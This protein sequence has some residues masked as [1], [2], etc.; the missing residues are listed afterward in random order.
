MDEFRLNWKMFFGRHRPA[1]DGVEKQFLAKL[2]DP[3]E[4]KQT[5]RLYQVRTE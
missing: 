4:D 1:L 2:N 5:M 3:N